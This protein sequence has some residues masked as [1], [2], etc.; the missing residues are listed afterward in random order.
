[1]EQRGG[2]HEMAVGLEGDTAGRLRVLQLLDEGEMAVHQH[3]SGERPQMCGRLELGRIRRQ[4]QQVGA[5][6]FPKTAGGQ[7][8]GSTP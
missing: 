2:A 3:G 5:I 8:M 6:R 1:M 7:G 4:K